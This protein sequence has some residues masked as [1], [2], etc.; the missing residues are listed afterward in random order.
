MAAETTMDLR[1]NLTH[2]CDCVLQLLLEGSPLAAVAVP[3][4][5]GTG[6]A[7]MQPVVQSSLHSFG[8]ILALA[9]VLAPCTEAQRQLLPLIVLSSHPLVMLSDGI[10]P[11]KAAWSAALHTHYIVLCTP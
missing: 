1:T 3:S 2:D 11:A 7:G 5:K 10:A 8:P 6:Q 9:T 4:S